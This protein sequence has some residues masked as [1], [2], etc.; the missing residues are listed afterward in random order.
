MKRGMG[1]V[2]WMWAL[3]AIAISLARIPEHI[4]VPYPQILVAV[5]TAL[6]FFGLVF[7]SGLR[8]WAR[9]LDLHALTVFHIWRIIPGIAFIMLHNRRMLA[10]G[11]AV[12][13]GWG[14]IAVGVA[15]PIVAAFFIDRRA[16]MLLWHLAGM[17]DLTIAVA[18]AAGFGM[19]LPAWMESLRHF[20]L[21]LL[22]LFA[23]PLTLQV[24]IS[25]IYLILRDYK[26]FREDHEQP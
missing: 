26:L 7:S 4:P 21:S 25:A 6:F 11:F 8:R 13:A 20:P 23:V 18:I 14:D 3:V 22:P 1:F 16:V 9:S 10:G 24:H 5:L 2:I 15:A 12:P 19:E 17:L